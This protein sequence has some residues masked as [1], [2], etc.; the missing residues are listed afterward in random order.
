MFAHLIAMIERTLV[1]V[2]PD[3]VQRGLIGECVRRFEQ[4]GFKIVG[5][6]MVHPDAATVAKHYTDSIE[7]LTS[8]G[9]NTKKSYEAKGINVDKTP[10]EIG[11]NVR[12]MLMEYLSTGPIVAIVV[13]GY[14]VVEIV[15]KLVG[16]TEPR[17]SAPG[18]IRGDF[19]SESYM[20]ADSKKRPVKNII[21]ASGSVKEAEEE[22]NVWFKPNDIYTY[23]RA[24]WPAMH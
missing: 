3:G 5:I 1:L 6:K 9:T 10:E 14:H 11:R 12:R 2:K 20:I 22:I 7:W 21:H 17:T 8:T 18:T 4:R 19:S 24:E 15:R 16:T 23:D 13:E